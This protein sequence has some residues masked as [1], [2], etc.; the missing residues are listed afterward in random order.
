MATTNLPFTTIELSKP[1]THTVVFPHD[2]GDNARAFAAR[3]REDLQAEG[4]REVVPAVLAASAALLGG[5]WDRLVL[6]GISTGGATAAHVLSNL[7]EA[8]GRLGAFVGFSW[9]CPPTW[10]SG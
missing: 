9:R 5:R 7:D 6:A 2:R 4:L 8:G 1:H 10:C 3:S